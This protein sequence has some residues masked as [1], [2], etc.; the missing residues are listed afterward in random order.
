MLAL[1]LLKSH[2]RPGLELRPL[3]E[4]DAAPLALLIERNRE[5]LRTWLGWLDGEW[6]PERLRMQIRAGRRRSLEGHGLELAIWFEQRLIGRISFNEIHA[7]HRRASVGYWVDRDAEGRGLV[8]AACRLLVHYG[9]TELQLER[10]EIRC[11]AGNLRS[12][13]VPKRLGFQLEGVLRH[14]ERLYDRYVDHVVFSMRRE[15]WAQAPGT[16]RP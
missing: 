5:H 4:H 12:Q 7:H 10:I 9:F 6:N 13:G 11:A 3:E 15:E 16:L 2:S 14:N 1:P 8:T